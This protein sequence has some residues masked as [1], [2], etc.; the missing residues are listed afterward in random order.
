[1]AG[2]VVWK[3]RR[4]AFK[5]SRLKRW[6]QRA[7]YFL[8]QCRLM[9]SPYTKPLMNFIILIALVCCRHGGANVPNEG[10]ET[11]QFSRKIKNEHKLQAPDINFPP[12]SLAIFFF[13]YIL[14]PESFR[15]RARPGNQFELIWIRKKKSPCFAW[16]T[17][18][19]VRGGC[20]CLFISN[21]QKLIAFGN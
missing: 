7:R 21:Y 13:F 5:R 12:S 14:I 4:K 15:R 11:I 2:H 10:A 8:N 19:N 9:C 3:W 20:G 17:A 16:C 6:I 1:M 18:F